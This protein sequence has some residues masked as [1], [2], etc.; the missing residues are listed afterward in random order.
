MECNHFLYFSWSSKKALAC[1]L[2]GC[3]GLEMICIV[4]FRTTE[5]LRSPDLITSSFVKV[6]TEVNFFRAV[7]Q[8]AALISE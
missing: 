5:A 1:A 3:S 6:L 2:I 7:N 4:L 8:A